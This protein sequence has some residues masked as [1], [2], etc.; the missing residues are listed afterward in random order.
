MFRSRKESL[1]G[2]GK[3]LNG[4]LNSRCLYRPQAGGH[5]FYYDHLAKKFRPNDSLRALLPFL[6]FP[7]SRPAYVSFKILRCTHCGNCIFE[8]DTRQQ[9][10][11]D[12][13]CNYCIRIPDFEYCRIGPRAPKCGL[14]KQL[15]K[16]GEYTYAVEGE[17]ARR[18]CVPLLGSVF[19]IDRA[20]MPNRLRRNN[21]EI[22]VLRRDYLKGCTR[23]R[24]PRLPIVHMRHTYGRVLTDDPSGSVMVIRSF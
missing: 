13:L 12:C 24:L 1:Y 9:G 23:A 2:T 6:K 16:S 3:F 20:K 10:C 18:V 14:P 15:F 11:I 5:S 4:D 22:R 7:E 17:G 19:R 21:E 8:D